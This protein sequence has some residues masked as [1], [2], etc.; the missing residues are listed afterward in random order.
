MGVQFHSKDKTITMH[1]AKT[2]YQM[3]IGPLGLLLHTYYG[4][5]AEGDLSYFIQYKDRGFPVIHTMPEGTGRSPQ[6]LSLWNTPVKE[7]AISGRR[8]YPSAFRMA[9]AD[10]IC[11]MTGTG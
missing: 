4:P 11:G 7:T 5:R 3:K 10:V 8:R 9:P 1:T 2:T 6:I